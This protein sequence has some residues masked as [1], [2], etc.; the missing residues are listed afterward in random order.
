MWWN[1]LLYSRKQRNYAIFSTTIVASESEQESDFQK[2]SREK[3][4][5]IPIIENNEISLTGNEV[6]DPSDQ[7]DLDL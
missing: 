6:L 2:K 1:R 7:L 3:L 4:T 5:Y